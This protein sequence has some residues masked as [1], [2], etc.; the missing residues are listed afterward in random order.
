M[1]T[2]DRRC[3]LLKQKISDWFFFFFRTEHGGGGFL[4]L[5]CFTLSSKRI[6]PSMRCLKNYIGTK[7]LGFLCRNG[8]LGYFLLEFQRLI[9][10]FRSYRCVCSYWNCLNAIIV[11]KLIPYH[12]RSWLEALFFDAPPSFL[13]S[14]SIEIEGREHQSI[15]YQWAVYLA[16]KKG[17][18]GDSNNIGAERDI[19]IEIYTNILIINNNLTRK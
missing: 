6:R 8:W 5:E 10:D 18:I 1:H 7:L 16:K 15:C 11:I 13:H 19:F 4:I 12:S 17:T 3:S 9:F 14:S 2:R